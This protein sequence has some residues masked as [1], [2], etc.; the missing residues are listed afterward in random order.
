MSD[1]N[2]MNM[3]D[4]LSSQSMPNDVQSMGIAEFLSPTE[5]R[6]SQNNITVCN[7]I[8]TQDHVRT[9]AP[10]QER[11]QYTHGMSSGGPPL[12]G[13]NIIV[14]G[15]AP[16]PFHGP[17]VV[18]TPPLHNGQR[19]PMPP[20]VSLPHHPS[21]PTH[22]PPVIHHGPPPHI[23]NLTLPPGHPY[24]PVEPGHLPPPPPGSQMMQTSL[25]PP[26]PPGSVIPRSQQ[27]GPPSFPHTQSGL[28]QPPLPGTRSTSS[29]MPPPSTQSIPPSLRHT[30]SALPPLPPP[31]PPDKVQMPPP[32]PP[33]PPLPPSVNDN[34]SKPPLPKGPP[35]SSAAAK[36][37]LSSPYVKPIKSLAEVER[38]VSSKERH[39]SSF[40]TSKNN[41]YFD[42]EP[43]PIP[44]IVT[45]GKPTT[46]H[47]S[48]SNSRHSYCKDSTP[49][50]PP[51][52]VSL[53]KSIPMDHSGN[54]SR[55]PEDVYDPEDATFSPTSSNGSP[56]D[57]NSVASPIKSVRSPAKPRPH[58]SDHRVMKYHDKNE[59]DKKKRVSF[60]KDVSFTEKNDKSPGESPV[61]PNLDTRLRLMFG[62][63]SDEEKSPKK[64]KKSGTKPNAPNSLQTNEEDDETRPLSPTPSP[65]LSRNLYLYWHKETLKAR[66]SGAIDLASVKVCSDQGKPKHN[67]Q[68]TTAGR[69]SLIGIPPLPKNLPTVPPPNYKSTLIEPPALKEGNFKVEMLKNIK[70]MHPY[71]VYES[72]APCLK[73]SMDTE[74]ELTSVAPSDPLD[75]K[76][77]DIDASECQE[78]TV[79]LVIAKILDDLK[80]IIRHEYLLT[81][82]RLPAFSPSSARTGVGWFQSSPHLTQSQ[83]MLYSVKTFSRFHAGLDSF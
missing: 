33:L 35:P 8:S 60:S 81:D 15:Q 65:F 28:P 66:K 38:Y 4:F 68:A 56:L 52:P 55:M 79:R 77:S 37:S 7:F 29:R 54:T 17:P 11:V 59:K 46:T 41:K 36:H 10:I 12:P 49:P 72:K 83:I 18:C 40:K 67:G 53:S 20:P 27:S 70:R 19:P 13:V 22:H 26:L 80:N 61:R 73:N 32:L 64:S 50:P 42:E 57:E 9:R 69:P 48:S 23:T 43:K 82:G 47:S 31:L 45:S 2:R 71:K 16:S 3:A 24:G 62:G 1:D 25:P 44:S 39:S 74:F 6:G 34:R 58:P 51:L 76:S 75:E 30:H 14:P 5:F 78:E 63:M 21:L